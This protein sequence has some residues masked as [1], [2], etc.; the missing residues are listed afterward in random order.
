MSE[1]EQPNLNFDD[2]FDKYFNG[3]EWLNLNEKMINSVPEKS[4][5]YVI[6]ATANGTD[7]KIPHLRGVDNQ[8]IILIGE[9]HGEKTGL[10]TR[11]TTFY[12]V[13]NGGNGYHSEGGTYYDTKEFQEKSY[14]PLDGLCFIYCEQSGGDAKKIER[15]LLIKF[16][17]KF[18]SG[19]P[20]NL[21]MPLTY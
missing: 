10:R 18:L 13:C 5:V 2:L 12:K 3:R 1:V 15:R 4:G 17:K 16:F 14:F 8:G 6:K 19:P 11:L 21:K 9:T 20:L 7:R